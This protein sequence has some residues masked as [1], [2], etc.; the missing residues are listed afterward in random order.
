MK[1]L[2]GW[3]WWM[4]AIGLAVLLVLVLQ[5]VLDDGDQ[6]APEASGTVEVMIVTDRP[7]RTATR[8]LATPSPLPT[9]TATATPSPTATA[10]PTKTPTATRDPNL[11]PP[12]PE[13]GAVWQRPQDGMRMIYVPPGTFPMG[14]EE[15]HSD[16][17]P[18]HDVTL[19]GFWL[20]ET[21][22]TNRQYSQC[23]S[24]GE[25]EASSYVGDAPYNGNEYPVVD[26]SWDD[27]DSYCHWAGGRLPSEAEWE[28][29]ARGPVGNIYPWGDEFDGALANYCD[30]NCTH[31]HRDVS[32]DDGYSNTAP[33]GSY[34]DG[35]SWI[36]ALDMAGNVWEWVNDWYDSDYYAVSPDE[37]PPGPKSGTY[38]VTR[39]GMADNLAV[40]LRSAFRN[41]SPPYNR[42]SGIGFRCVWPGS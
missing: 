14:S 10:N 3:F 29:A 17:E 28:Y 38:K 8:I 13:A 42:T 19:D 32:F 39:G 22:V 33:A 26:V 9:S 36:G 34:P 1:R 12:E 24:A 16:D 30:Q 6:A 40:S 23:F 2:P 11:P 15:G 27:A 4:G 7:S 37:N 41:S 5:A 25:C 18:V 20:D 31:S 35:A 21:E